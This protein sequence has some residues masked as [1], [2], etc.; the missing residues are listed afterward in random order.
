MTPRSRLRC[1]V[2]D[3]ALRRMAAG[4]ACLALPVAACEAR[5][6]EAEARALLEQGRAEEAV[7]LLQPEIEARSGNPRLYHLYGAA[8]LQSGQPSLATWPLQR[9][10]QDPEQAVESGLLLA[11]AL[12]TGGSPHDAVWAASAVLERD[13]DNAGALGLRA[14][15]SLRSLD[16]E[17]ALRDIERLLALGY[18]ADPND[19][20]LLQAKLEAELR[21][22]RSEDAERTIALLRARAAEAENFPEELAARL[23]A[24]D[25]VFSAEKGDAVAARAQ[26]EACLERHPAAHVV[27]QEAARYFDAQGEFERGTQILERAVEAAPDD[28]PLRIQLAARLRDL[29]RSDEA[30]DTLRDLAERSGAPLAWTALADHFVELEDLEGAADALGRAVQ[31]QTSRALDEGGFYDVPDAGLFAYADI[32]VQ[33]GESTHARVRQMLPALEEPAYAHFLEGRMRLVSGD[34]AGADAAY[35]AGLRLW[36]SN[37]GARYLAGQAAEQL[38][39]FVAAI[40]HYREA[41]RADASRSPAGLALARIQI[42]QGNLGAALDALRFHLQGHDGDVHAL[43]LYADVAFQMGRDEESA[44]ARRRMAAMPGQAARA[45]ADRAQDLARAQGV[46]AALVFLES[47]RLDLDDP[48]HAPALDAWCALLAGQGRH[49]EALARIDGLLARHPQ[50]AALHAA[51]GAALHRAGR[52]A[53]ARADLGR[54]LALDARQLSALVMLA[55]L[56]GAAGEIDEAVALYDRASEVEPDEPAHAYAAASLRLEA[57][58]EADAE[59]RFESLLRNFAWHGDAAYALAQRALARG[60][61][62]AR[63]LDLAQRAARFRA[64]PEGI[65]LLGRMLLTRGESDQAVAVL[66]HA[67]ALEEPGPGTQY[68]LGRAL[69][70]VGDLDGARAAYRAAIDSESGLEVASARRELARLEADAA[71]P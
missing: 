70:A 21:L 68:Y 45:V 6:P 65:V 3:R 67:A 71:A 25:A 31:A 24:L 39:D 62:D 10:A 29:G 23:C 2:S 35:R 12:L 16:E 17:P 9:A 15:G 44:G 50:V 13:P 53:E 20:S 61:T 36:P 30:G 40:S 11:R 8:L 56:S 55:A 49:A 18:G 14:Q 47:S 19:V 63:A 64:G 34:Y 52:D 43:R 33:L 37:P 5:H 54:A 66:R 46:E 60:A 22:G 7:A 26:H 42:A 48:A 59:Q 4:I 58:A 32:L 27:V 38:G 41:I 69:A 28:L 1:R 57:R 51:R